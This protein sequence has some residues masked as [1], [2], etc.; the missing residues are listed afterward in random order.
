MNMIGPNFM[1]IVSRQCGCCL[2]AESS[3]SLFLFMSKLLIIIRYTQLKIT[4]NTTQSDIHLPVFIS[5]YDFGGALLRSSMSG[6]S[7]G[8]SPVGPWLFLFKLLHVVIVAFVAHLSRYKLIEPYDIVMLESSNSS[9][10]FV[11]N[12]NG[13]LSL[14]WRIWV[15]FV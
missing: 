7:N 10:N 8:L 11:S 2:V 4:F 15:L 13:F 14:L 1:M 12:E 6:G 5:L 3:V 9:M